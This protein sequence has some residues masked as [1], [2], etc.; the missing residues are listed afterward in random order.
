MEL[1]A[2]ARGEH[3]RH[4]RQQPGLH[5]QG[6]LGIGA[7]ESVHPACFALQA[8]HLTQIDADTDRQHRQEH[9]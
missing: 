4:R 8:H 7:A 2:L 9:R 5:R 1:A 3:A 6:A